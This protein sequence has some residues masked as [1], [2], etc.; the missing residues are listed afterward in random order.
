MFIERFAAGVE[1]FKF[2]LVRGNFRGEFFLGEGR[3]FDF[4]VEVLSRGKGVAF[5]FDFVVRDDD[6]EAV[7]G[8]LLEEGVFDF[9]DFVVSE[10]C[11]FVVAVFIFFAELGG[12]DEDDFFSA[13]RI[14]EEDDGDVCAGGG[15]DVG[16]HGDAA[17]DDMVFDDVFEDFF[18][19]GGFGGDKA[20]WDDDGAFAVGLEGIEQVLDEAKEDFHRGLGGVD[21]LWCGWDAGEEA[22]GIFCDFVALIWEVEFE[23]G[24][25]DDEVEMFESAIWFAVAWVEEGIALDDVLDGFGEV[26]EDEVEAEHL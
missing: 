24:I 2:G 23:R 1:F 12:V 11:T 15:E 3:V 4:D 21:F 9:F 14:I 20:C 16:G 10:A 7:F 26:I 13:A 18:L 17:V 25:R 22:V 5:F 6:G 8:F 19:D